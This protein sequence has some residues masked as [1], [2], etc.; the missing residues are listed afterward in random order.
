EFLLGHRIEEPTH[1]VGFKPQGCFELVAGYGFIIIGAVLVGSSVQGSTGFG[2]NLKMLLISH[3][4]RP[5]EH[6]M[7]KEMGKPR[8]THHLTCRT[9][10]VGYIHMYNGIRMVFMDNNGKPV[11]QHIFFVGDDYF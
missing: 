5:L 11:I 2:H 8:T 4:L 1:T 9:Y 3:V 6:H 7:L 10:M